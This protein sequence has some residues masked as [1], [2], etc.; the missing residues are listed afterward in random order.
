MPSLIVVDNP[1]HWPFDIPGVEVVD[2]RT[3]LTHQEYGEIRGVK[4][5]NLCRSY[6]YQS[7]GYYV[8]LL[9]A[10]R[11]HKPLPSIATVQ[12]L[13]TQSVIR[14]V[15]E[16]LDELVQ[17]SLATIQS[18][19]F[20]FSI[21]FGRNLARRYD[22]LAWHLFSLF[23]APLLRAQFVRND[24]WQL[25]TVRAISTD[26]VPES[27]R[28]FL[29]Q[30]ATDYFAG[31][32]ARPPKR[33]TAKYDV[34]ILVDP[35]EQTPPSDEAAIKRFIKAGEGMGLRVEVIER[36]DYPRVAEYDGLFIRAT[37]AVDH[38]TYRFAR[39]A[40]VEGLVVIDDP[41]SIIRCTNKVFLA[42][43]LARHRIP[44]PK[45]MVIHRDNVQN[46]VK[47][48]GLP[49]VLKQPDS[50]FSRG[51]VKVDSEATLSEQV[52]NFLSDSELVI[53]Q[54]FLPT[55]FDWRIG[56]L[57][58]KPLYACQY[59][60]ARGHWQIYK[61][62]V[63]GA[64]KEGDFKTLPVELAPR[65]LTR[66]A[67][68]A[69]NL[70]GNGLYGVDLKE[71]GDECYVIEVNDN[72]SIESGVEDQ[73]LREELHQRIMSVFLRRIELKKMGIPVE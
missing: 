48:L 30:A 19:R 54:E 45:T 42:E 1:K 17:K 49:C 40:A 47:E 15:S 69:A 52:E 32:R 36:D 72:P 35:S 11:G 2:A 3:Y 67:L 18:K 14:S 28:L 59:F 60:M 12:D 68:K 24:K 53:A 64:P 34:A 39:R 13:K 63:S 55:P 62:V 46:I 27:H 65:R 10:A 66:T 9:A 41:E 73:V 5:F 6:R 38:H 4:V 25:R 31:R 7:V 20:P 57:D 23:P 26:E 56:V 70:I 21:Y 37:T 58:G 51:V 29:L 16:E 33:F 8:T 61:H 71:I 50:S 22:R 44:T 43:L